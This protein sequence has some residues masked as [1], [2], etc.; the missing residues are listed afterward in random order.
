MTNTTNHTNSIAEPRL[1][2]LS[3]SPLAPGTCVRCRTRICFLH[4]R[5][6]DGCLDARA[7]EGITP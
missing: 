5:L 6:C 1:P 2:A 7:A 4:V 3:T